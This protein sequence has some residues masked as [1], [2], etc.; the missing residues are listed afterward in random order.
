MMHLMEEYA[1]HGKVKSGTQEKNKQESAAMRKSSNPSVK[2]TDSQSAG[3]KEQREESTKICK[4]IEQLSK[5]LTEA[6]KKITE[7]SNLTK[8]SLDKCNVQTVQKNRDAN[9]STR[10]LNCYII[11]RENRDKCCPR[12]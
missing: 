7:L 3:N 5:S 4:T 8:M 2:A 6:N 1:K 9:S 12:L 11:T 10:L